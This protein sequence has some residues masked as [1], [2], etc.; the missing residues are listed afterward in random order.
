MTFDTLQMVARLEQAGIPTEHAKAQVMMLADVLATEHAGYAETYSTKS[1]INQHLTN[2][3][4]D[5]VLTNVKIDQHVVE[6]NAK[7]DRHAIELNAK[8][9]QHASEFNAKLEKT[10]TKID[11]H[12]VEFN[13][14]LEKTN[15]KIDQ[16]AV[17]FN[18]KLEMLDSKSDKRTS[19]LKAELIRWVV[20]VSTL[21]GTLISA[22]L[23]R[24]H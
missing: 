7:I 9:D 17:E 4:K 13:A 18:A 2:I 14:K 19:E 15:T 5:L 23:L 16:H 6:L 21:Q 20:A 10:N 24:L 12:A 22:L 8:I 1:D 3:D 11:Q